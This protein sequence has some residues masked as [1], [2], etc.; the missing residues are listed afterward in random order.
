MK[1][2]LCTCWIA[3]LLFT[4]GCGGSGTTSNVAEDADAK[5]LADYNALIE[6]QD[7][8]LADYKE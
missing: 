6:A 5:A 3:L 8:E 1:N 4:A 2:F 7:A